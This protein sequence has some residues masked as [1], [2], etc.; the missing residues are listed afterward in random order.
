MKKLYSKKAFITIN[1]HKPSFPN[2]V[3]CRLINIMKSD[4]GKVAKLILD[5]MYCNIRDNTDVVQ[6]KNYFEVIAWFDKLSNANNLN[7]LKFDISS[8]YPLIRR[9]KLNKAMYFAPTFTKL[10]WM[11]KWLYFILVQASF[12]I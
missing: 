6:W 3:D 8:F 2:S 11:K 7:F 9:Y 5:K 1:D 4:W 12:Q 10:V